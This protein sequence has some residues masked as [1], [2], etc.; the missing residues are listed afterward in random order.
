MYG[1]QN[2]IK[3]GFGKK[4]MLKNMHKNLTFLRAKIYGSVNLIKKLSMT[5][6]VTVMSAMMMI[7]PASAAST[8]IWS[9]TSDIMKSVYG[10]ILG[11]DTGL[12]ALMLVICFLTFQVSKDE[13]KQQAARSWAIKISLAWVGINL[14]GYIIAYAQTTVGTDGQVTQWTSS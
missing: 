13:R 4:I 3:K 8:D 11:I 5:L 14:L 7:Q 2:N 1:T 12:A 10:K 9:K 6:A